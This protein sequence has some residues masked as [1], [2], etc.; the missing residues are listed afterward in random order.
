VIVYYHNKVPNYAY[1]AL[2][3]HNNAHGVL[4]PLTLLNMRC[5]VLAAN[6][7]L[8]VL[9]AIDV[10]CYQGSLRMSGGVVF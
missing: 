9:A 7:P 5:R 2:I 1:T 6:V 4:L 3:L 8:A 10:R